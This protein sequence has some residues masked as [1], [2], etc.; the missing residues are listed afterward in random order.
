MWDLELGIGKISRI[1]SARKR[2]LH[3]KRAKSSGAGR[4]SGRSRIL[5]RL[6]WI[7]AACLQRLKEEGLFEKL[8]D[9]ICIGQGYRG[10]TGKLGIGQCTRKFEYHLEGCP[11]TEGAIYEFLKEYLE[12]N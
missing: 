9:K 5:Q 1:K 8:Q 2:N 12:E 3:T 4:C 11:P 6:L 7:L 10:K